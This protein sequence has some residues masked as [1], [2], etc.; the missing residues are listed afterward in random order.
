MTDLA[1]FTSRW[2]ANW[3]D[4]L[5][6]GSLLRGHR[7]RWVRFHSLPGSKRYP[8]TDD[9]TGEM[10]FRYNTVLGEL[11]TSDLSV[12]NTEQLLYVLTHSW[13]ESRFPMIRDS[14][15]VH[16]LP[17]A[18]LWQSLPPDD[19]S[20]CWTHVWVSTTVWA[21]GA[22]DPLFTLVG[23]D[24]TADVIIM[25]RDCT[26]AH[27]PYDGGSDVIAPSTAVRDLLASRHRE[28]LSYR[29]DGL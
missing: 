11:V 10:L 12:S 14:D 5:P 7:D 24:G 20:E 18:E 2:R 22:L 17:D 23:D 26:W 6:I 1:A 21:P 16:A 19:Y 13:S 15:L 3:A 28:W 25:D 8:E 29:A 4:E 27:H 9:E